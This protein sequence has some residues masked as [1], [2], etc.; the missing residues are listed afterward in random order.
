MGGGRPYGRRGSLQIGDFCDSGTGGRSSRVLSG[1]SLTASDIL[2]MTNQNIF[3]L[4]CAF[5]LTPPFPS[6][7]PFTLKKNLHC[8]ET[9]EEAF[10]GCA[11]SGPVAEGRHVVACFFDFF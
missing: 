9:V 5:L 11:C 10:V 6:P 1:N 8:D 3:H 2:N 7:S 4:M